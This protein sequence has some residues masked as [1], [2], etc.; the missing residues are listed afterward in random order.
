MQSDTLDILKQLQSPLVIIGVALL[1]LRSLG[2][3]LNQ[4]GFP[5]KLRHFLTASI[6]VVCCLV[7]VTGSI[8][9]FRASW[10]NDQQ[11]ENA[12]Q[13]TD[14][15]SPS[16]PSQKISEKDNETM[17]SVDKV[18]DSSSVKTRQDDTRPRVAVVDFKSNASEAIDLTGYSADVLSTQLARTGKFNLLKR[19]RLAALLEEQGFSQSGAVDPATA[20]Q[21]GKLF[22][23]EYLATGTIEHLG[24]DCGKKFQGYGVTIGTCTYNASVMIEVFDTTTG[25]VLY[26]ET[27]SS[28]ES[29][30]STPYLTPGDVSYRSLLDKAIRPLA[31]G[32][33]KKLAMTLKPGR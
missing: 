5:E 8:G 19:N 7:I 31:D 16:P 24:K 18:A 4:K 30:Q 20:V 33:S 22:G 29:T 11:P 23:A 3:I 6:V 12:Q 2:P 15:P 1:L 28:S 32:A 13:V 10:K 17:M 14:P 26:A 21:L 25:A 9:Y 27:R